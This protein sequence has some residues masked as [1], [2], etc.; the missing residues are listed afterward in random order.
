MFT[1][2][3]VCFW[4]GVAVT[5]VNAL[6]GLI[7]G[8]FDFGLDFD[9]DIDLDIGDF[10]LGMFLP[11]SPT[12]LFLFLTVFGG[13]GMIIANGLSSM[14][15]LACIIALVLGIAVITL[16]NV[17]VV[18]PLRKISSKE[19]AKMSDFVGET[20]KVTE[21]IFENGFGKITFIVDGNTLTYPAKS[22]TGKE[23][24]VGTQ[25]FVESINDKYFV[26]DL[27]EKKS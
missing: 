13:S 3:Q 4:V 12:L 8:I 2:F 10:D 20:G 23:I 19:T 24:A 27:L 17:F 9:F 11:L 25:V 6:L 21:K 15:W 22:V 1:V 16:I 18:R 14:L 5:G 7:F 26:V